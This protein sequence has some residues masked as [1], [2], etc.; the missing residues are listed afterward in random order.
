MNNLIQ[1][2]Y[3]WITANPDA[4]YGTTPSKFINAIH[5]HP[6]QFNRLFTQVCKEKEIKKYLYMLTFTL[7][8]DIDISDTDTVEAY[9][10][11]QMSRGPLHIK[12]S[13]YVRELTKA[14]RPHWHV[15]VETTK[16]LKKDRFNYY[17]KKYGFVQ[18]NKSSH[19]N[20]PTIINYL[21]K[22]SLPI[23]ISVVT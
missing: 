22:D 15:A 14:N 12:K 18:I 16:P 11:K 8:D 5:K 10:L 7:R 19:K 9:I 3:E 21:S 2:Y 4:K 6:E 20:Y 23:C 17:E 13:H 1:E